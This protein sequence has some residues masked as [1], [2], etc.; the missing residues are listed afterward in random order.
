MSHAS[1]RK[2]RRFDELWF[3][4]DFSD[5]VSRW[6]LILRFIKG[7]IHGAV[8]VPVT[9]HALFTAAV[10]YIDNNRD[11]NLGLPASIV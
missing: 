7:S 3:S 4:V 2:P 5:L 11:H 10:V 8:A 1:R 9:F 6:P